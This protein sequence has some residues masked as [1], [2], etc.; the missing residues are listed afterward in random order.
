MKCSFP[1][2]DDVHSKFLKN[3]ADK[4]VI[5]LSFI[6]TNSYNLATFPSVWKKSYVCPIY[7]CAGS[8]FLPG[9]Y[10]PEAFTSI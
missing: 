9:N 5:P 10:R 3:L 7:K 1:G 4:L 2:P 8:R 6:F